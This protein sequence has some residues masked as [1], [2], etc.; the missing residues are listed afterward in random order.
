MILGNLHSF[1]HFVGRNTPY[2]DNPY[3][4]GRRIPNWVDADEWCKEHS[5]PL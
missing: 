3:K 5:F 1:A 4:F 2:S